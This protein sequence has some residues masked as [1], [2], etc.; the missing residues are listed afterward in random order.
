LLVYALARSDA[1]ADARSE[2][3]RMATAAHP[4]PVVGALRAYL[5][6]TAKD[7]KGRAAGSSTAVD[8]GALPDARRP[9]PPVGQGAPPGPAPQGPLPG[10]RVPDDYVW[11]GYGDDDKTAAPTAPTSAPSATPAP[12]PD[13][14]DPPVS[15]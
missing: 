9:A 1:A 4:L 7:G 11:P 3:D 13:T 6:R 10:G 14:P 5:D 12:K 2:L 15:P 8:V